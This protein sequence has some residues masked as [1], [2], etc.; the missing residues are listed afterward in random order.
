MDIHNDKV[1]KNIGSRLKAAREKSNRTQAEVA[2]AADMHVNYY[3]RI[4]RGEVNTSLEKL[5]KI[6]VTLKVRSS[7]IFPF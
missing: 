5:H 2:A 7:D 1:R 6:M 4:E 3:A